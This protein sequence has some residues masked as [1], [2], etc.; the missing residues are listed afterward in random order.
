VP[1]CRHSPT[2]PK[3]SSSDHR[4]AEVTATFP[5]NGG[6]FCGRVKYQLS[7]M[8]SSIGICHCQTCRRIAGAESVGWAV[9]NKDA[10][11]FTQGN[12]RGFQSSEGVERT[13]CDNCGTTIT[14]CRDGRKLVDVTLATLDDPELLQPT[15]ETWCGDRISWNQLNDT[16]DHYEGSSS[17]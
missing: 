13:F 15:K 10:F 6:C 8:P 17:S 7:E 16:L 3:W 2:Q 5:I 12:A 1:H 4:N 11:S 14:Y 9:I